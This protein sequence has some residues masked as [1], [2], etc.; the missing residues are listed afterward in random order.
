VDSHV[1]AL[2]FV[3]EELKDPGIHTVINFR[4][5]VGLATS[6]VAFTTSGFR[7]DNPKLFRAF[8][9]ALQ[10]AQALIAADRK[11][12]AEVYLAVSND[13][14]SSVEDIVK[15]L[16]DP[17]VTFVSAP[18]N[19]MKY[20][21]FMSGIGSIKVRPDSWKDLFFPEIHGAAGS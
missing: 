1:T 9:D 5:V 3:Y 12:A 4:D 7:S 14:R 2:P 16:N 8:L 17:D 15:M 6:I 18:F 13:K 20:V 10:E 19:T 11:S 21:D